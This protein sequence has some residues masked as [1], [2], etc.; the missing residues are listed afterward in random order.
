MPDLLNVIPLFAPVSGFSSGSFLLSDGCRAVVEE[1]AGSVYGDDEE[2]VWV[3]MSVGKY[4]RKAIYLPCREHLRVA[5]RLCF[6][7]FLF[8]AALGCFALFVCCYL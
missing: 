4:R 8:Q 3:R 2:N 1:M 6:S 7:G 5:R